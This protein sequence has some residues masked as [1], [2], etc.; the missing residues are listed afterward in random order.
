MLTPDR[1]YTIPFGN[2]AL[3][4]NEK[5]IPD[6]M[7]APGNILN[8]KGGIAYEKGDPMKSL[9][10]VPLSQIYGVVAHN[11]NDL[12]NVEDDGE[13]Y[14]RA[15]LNWAM[16]GVVVHFYVD[17]LCAWQNLNIDGWTNPGYHA[18]CGPKIVTGNKGIQLNGN[19]NCFGVEIIM[20]GDGSEAD[21][22]AERNGAMLI[23]WLLTKLDSRNEDDV[24]SHWY[25]ANDKKY[26]P[27]FI[28]PHWEE[29]KK[30][31]AYYLSILQGKNS[32]FTL[33]NLEGNI[34]WRHA[35]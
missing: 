23:A 2:E 10:H 12:A 19:V 11:T 21:K 16:G 34:A 22:K 6:N 5:I 18:G 32:G 35:A 4:I 24:Y 14:T 17:D 3:I 28:L 26:C 31:I 13:Q 27:A 7:Y 29:F 15:T 9:Q 1:T 33:A 8:A 25:F 30:Q 20:Q